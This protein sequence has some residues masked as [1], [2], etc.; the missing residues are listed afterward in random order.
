MAIRDTQTLAAAAGSASSTDTMLTEVSI[1]DGGSAEIVSTGTTLLPQVLM[2][3]VVAC[4]VVAVFGTALVVWLLVRRRQRRIM[5]HSISAYGEK[6]MLE[7][8]NFPGPTSPHRSSWQTARTWRASQALRIPSVLSPLS[9]NFPV[10]PGYTRV[11]H[12]STLLPSPPISPM[13]VS[14]SRISSSPPPLYSKLEGHGPERVMKAKA[15]MQHYTPTRPRTP[16]VRNL[17]EVVSSTAS[18]SSTS[19]RTT[20]GSRTL[21]DTDEKVW[22][23][24]EE[25]K[26][27][28]KKPQ[29]PP[30]RRKLVPRPLVPKI[31]VTRASVIPVA[32]RESV[33]QRAGEL[34]VMKTHMEKLEKEFVE[35]MAAATVDSPTRPWRHSVRS[36][37][38]V[39]HEAPEYSFI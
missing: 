35:E 15:T 24:A 2:P 25:T 28:V 18:D 4:A 13:T 29:P 10:S 19:S 27:P 5:Q 16:E 23:K 6:P 11:K 22:W 30:P 8:F 32:F 1:T 39:S 9:T 12:Q 34:E 26:T 36:S 7:A 38:T 37:G 14:T 21:K 33:L 17:M 31:Q 3:I 20:D